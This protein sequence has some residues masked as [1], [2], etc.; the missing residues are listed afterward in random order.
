M[1]D[2][3]SSRLERYER[4]LE[5]HRI[6]NSAVTKAQRVNRERNIPN[7][8]SRGGKLYYELPDGTLTRTDPFKQG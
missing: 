5:L 6:G 7:S 3:K 2:E 8:Y 4:V 1:A